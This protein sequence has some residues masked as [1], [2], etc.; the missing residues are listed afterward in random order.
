MN[1]QHDRR[2]L[3]LAGNLTTPGCADTHQTV[4]RALDG[5]DRLII[6]CGEAE[7]IDVSFLQILVAAQQAAARSNKSVALAAPPQ[8]VLAQAL[9]RCGFAPPAGATALVEIFGLQAR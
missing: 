3:V 1:I 2:P 4:G 7:E 8:G 5:C 9:T 6:D